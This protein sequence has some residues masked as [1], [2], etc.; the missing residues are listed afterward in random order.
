MSS[1]IV[2]TTQLSLEQHKLPLSFSDVLMPI[3]IA[4]DDVFSWQCKKN[5]LNHALFLLLYLVIH[6]DERMIS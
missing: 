2:S 5:S 1:I 4:E 6:V 3:Q